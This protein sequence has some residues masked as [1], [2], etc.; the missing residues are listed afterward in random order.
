MLGLEF[1]EYNVSFKSEEETFYGPWSLQTP[2][3]ST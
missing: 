2:L 1:P 3:H